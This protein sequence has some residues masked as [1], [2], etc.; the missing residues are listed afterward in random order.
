MFGRMFDF[1][2]DGK[3]DAMELS[4]ALSIMEEDEI[5]EAEDTLE[6]I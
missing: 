4:I 3:S 2:R 6:Q 1:N 5:E